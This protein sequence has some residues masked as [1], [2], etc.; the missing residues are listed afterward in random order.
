M[1]TKH[2]IYLGV[3]AA[4]GYVLTSTLS[5]QPGGSTAYAIGYNFGFSGQFS[6]TPP[7]TG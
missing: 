6:T 7:T 4:V 2:L 5:Q 1:N 3:A